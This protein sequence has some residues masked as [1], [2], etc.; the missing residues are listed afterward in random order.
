MWKLAMK[1]GRG[2]LLDIALI[3]SL[4]LCTNAGAEQS[5][6]GMLPA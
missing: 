2:R 6:A 5:Q 4:P 3:G 1:S